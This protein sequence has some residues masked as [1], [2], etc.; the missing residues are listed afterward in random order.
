MAAAPS[1]QLPAFGPRRPRPAPPRL[2]PRDALNATPSSSRTGSASRN[3]CVAPRGPRSLCPTQGSRSFPTPRTNRPTPAPASRAAPPREPT[4]AS[5]GQAGPGTHAAPLHPQPAARAH[6]PHSR[7]DHHR[8][9]LTVRRAPPSAS[10]HRDDVTATHWSLHEDPTDWLPRQRLP[11]RPASDP[12]GRP[13]WLAAG[14]ALAAGD[15]R[16]PR[17]RGA[18]HGAAAGRAGAAAVLGARVPAAARAAA[19][20]GAGCPGAGD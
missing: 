3:R 18:R 13:H 16:G 17:L 5:C 4:P 19:G 11:S 12:A 6:R 9:R 10:A 15:S 20:P 8:P 1:R 2:E 7:Y 14:V